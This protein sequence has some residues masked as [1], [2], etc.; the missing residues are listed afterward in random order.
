MASS[1]MGHKGR[2]VH[3]AHTHRDHMVGK[4]HIQGHRGHN[5]GHIQGH[6][7]YMDR[8]QMDHKEGK[9]VRM[10]GRV[11]M[12]DMVRSLESKGHNLAH[13]GCKE[14]TVHSR[15]DCT[16]HLDRCSHKNRIL[17]SAR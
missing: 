15:L 10:V 1:Q 9:L 8:S 11:R 5:R 12:E 16:V 7:D 13:K 6:R 17:L 2:R 14:G 3:M 4:D